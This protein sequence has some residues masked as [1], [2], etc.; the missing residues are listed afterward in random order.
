[1]LNGFKTT[2]RYFWRFKG[3]ELIYG[4]PKPLTSMGISPDVEKIDGAMVWGHNK[5]TYL[6]SGTQYW[7]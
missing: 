6:F 3:I 5:K 2:G 1:M 4:Y 7:R